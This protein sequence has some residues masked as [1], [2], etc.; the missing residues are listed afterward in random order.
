MGPVIILIF[1][2][3]SGN[4]ANSSTIPPVISWLQYL[5]P[6]KYGYQALFQNEFNGL[7]FTCNNG[8][9]VS[10]P[11]GSINCTPGFS[12]GS[13]VIQQY[14]L[15]NISITACCFILL[16]FGFFF[17]F[18]GYIALLISLKPRMVLDVLEEDPYASPGT[19]DDTPSQP[20]QSSSPNMTSGSDPAST[21]NTF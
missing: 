15:G 20:M 1:F 21:L 19:L 12:T 17:I 16:G 9:P 13:Q 6:I 18:A 2:I 14:E 8:Q 7:S 5:S 4:L 3:Y 11:N 10:S